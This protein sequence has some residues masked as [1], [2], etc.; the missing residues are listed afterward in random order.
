M[1]NA[2]AIGMLGLLLVS[3]RAAAQTAVEQAAILREFQRS[4]VDYSERQAAFATFPEAAAAASPAPKIF[5]LPVAMVFRQLIARAI[6][7]PDG[8]PAI[9]STHVAHRAV[10]QEPV[11]GYEMTDFPDTLKE[12][13][14]V[15]PA[16]LEYRLVD[17]DLVIRD[18]PGDVVVAVLRDA[19]NTTTVVKR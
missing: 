12:A 5:T 16:T 19:V 4:V 8:A 15:L 11:P 6:A 13:L 10:L 3:N 17:R 2:I 7:G 9:R 14:P 1:K 18:V